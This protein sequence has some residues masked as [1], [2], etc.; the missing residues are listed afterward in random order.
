MMRHLAA[1]RR[2]AFGRARSPKS[3]S[4]ER[5]AGEVVHKGSNVTGTRPVIVLGLRRQR[6]ASQ[7]QLLVMPRT[8]RWE[9]P[10]GM[11]HRPTPRGGGALCPNALKEGGNVPGERVCGTAPPAHRPAA[12][13]AYCGP[14]RVTAFCRDQHADLVRGL[15]ARTVVDY[16]TQDLATYPDRFDLVFDAVGK[17]TFAASKPLLGNSGR[18]VSSE[19]GP[20]GENLYLPLTTRLRPGPTVHFP[21]PTGRRHSIRHM[22]RL[23]ADGRFRPL[24]DRRFPLEDV[25]SAYEYVLTGQKLGNVILDLRSHMSCER[26]AVVELD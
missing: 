11:K 25:R 3:P 24:I 18:Y 21:L 8:Q 4:G 10:S 20:H 6:L 22:T 7:E 2:D 9:D 19:L 17:T 16:T 5:F 26:S 1:S 14:G 12:G 15:G 13:P 23:L